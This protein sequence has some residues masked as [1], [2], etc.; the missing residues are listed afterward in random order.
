MKKIYDYPVLI[1]HE[2]GRYVASCPSFHG[3]V[4][5]A[6]TYEE[7]IR[8]I[9]EGITVFIETY[10]KHRWPL[11]EHSTPAMTLVKVAVNG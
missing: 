10:Q 2:D 3:C 4:A 1:D 11:P 6:E 8:E 5:Q 9:T 7:A